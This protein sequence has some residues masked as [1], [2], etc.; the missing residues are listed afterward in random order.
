MTSFAALILFTV[1]YLYAGHCAVTYTALSHKVF[2]GKPVSTILKY[3][4]TVVTWPI[5]MWI[6]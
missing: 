6:W 1:V 3:A 5:S 4:L 2:D